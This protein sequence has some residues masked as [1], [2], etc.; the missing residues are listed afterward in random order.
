MDAYHM[1]AVRDLKSRRALQSVRG[2]GH[3][4]DHVMAGGGGFRRSMNCREFAIDVTDAEPRRPRVLERLNC[5]VAVSARPVGLVRLEA[6][7]TRTCEV[8]GFSIA[9]LPPTGPERLSITDP[10]R[11]PGQVGAGPHILRYKIWRLGR[12][13]APPVQGMVGCRLLCVHAPGSGL[14][15]GGSNRNGDWRMSNGG[16][17][18]DGENIYTPTQGR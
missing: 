13:L 15:I 17:G 10:A 9:A 5:G 7:I 18:D 11:W 1:I 16:N 3:I 4:V 8:L 14:E 2:L 6:E 12:S